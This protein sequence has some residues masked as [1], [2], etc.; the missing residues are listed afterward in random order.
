MKAQTP[1]FRKFWFEIRIPL[2]YFVIGIVWIFFSDQLVDSHFHDIKSIAFFSI[3]KGLLYV[4]VTT[5]LLFY[6][7]KRHMKKVNEQQ[8]LMET[9]FETITDSI[10]ITDPERKVI[11]VNH[12]FTEAFGYDENEIRGDSSE[13]FY[14][15]KHEFKTFGTNFYSKGS[16]SSDDWVTLNCRKKDNTLFPAQAFAAKLIDHEG[17]WIGNLGVVHDLSEQYQYQEQIEK[18]KQKELEREAR[19]HFIL[20]NMIE[21]CQIISFDWHYLYINDVAAEH[22]GLPKEDHLNR[23]IHECYPDFIKTAGFRTLERCMIERTNL[24]YENEFTYPDGKTVWFDMSIQPVPEGIFILS[25]DITERKKT[26]L[27]VQEEKAKLE[28]AIE[29]MTDAVCISD[30]QGN[31][32]EFNKSF[33]TFHK[34]S[35]KKECAKTLGEYPVFLDVWFPDGRL[36]PMDQWAVP[37]ALRGETVSNAEYHLQRKDTGEQWIGSYSFAPIR[38]KEGNIT[39]SVVVGRDITDQKKAEEK[40]RYQEMILNETGR[41]AKVGG[42]EIDVPSEKVTWTDELYFLHD[43]DLNTPLTMHKVIGF[44]PEESRLILDTCMNEAITTAKPFD[45]EVRINTDIGRLI[46]GRIIG[47][48]VVNNGKV[49]KVQ[50]S[51]QDITHRKEAEEII[52]RSEEKYQLVAENSN[53]WVYLVAPDKN[54]VFVSPS[55][56]R[57]TGYAPEE[58]ID[59]PGRMMKIIYP[60]DKQFMETHFGSM[61]DTEDTNPIEFRILTKTGDV[62]WIS[63]TCSPIFTKDNVYVGRRGINRD[64]TKEKEATDKLISSEGRYRSLFEN[65]IEGFAYCKMIYENGEPVDWLYIAV[66]NSFERLTGLKDINGRYVSEVIPGIRESDPELF[67]TYARVATTGIPEKFETYVNALEMWFW[68]SV[69]SPL[70]DHFVAV[71]DVITERKKREEELRRL[72]TELEQLVEERAAELSDLYNNAP[73]GYHSLD[74]NGTFVRI[75]DTELKWLGYSR[76]EIIGKKRALDL[77]T[78]ASCEIFSRSFP[79]FKKSKKLENIELEFNRKD[80]TILPVLLNATALDDSDGNFMMS[81]STM[82]DYTERRLAD[83][84]IRESQEQLQAM[85]KELEAFAYSVSHDLRAPLRAIDGFMHIIYEDYGDC[86]DEEGHRLFDVVRTNARKMD[87]LITDLLALSRISRGDLIPSK[88]DMNKL[89][90]SVYFELTVPEIREEVLFVADPLPAAF[91]DTTLIR[92]IWTNLLGNALKYTR[93]KNERSIHIGGYSEEEMNIFFVKDNGVGFDPRYAH[94]LFGIFQRLHKTTEFEGTGV[95]LA[96]VQRIIFRHGGKVW[97][98]GEPNAGATFYFS[99]P[100]KIVHS[101]NGGNYDE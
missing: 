85:N 68:I 95:G 24:R 65:L 70:K 76:D 17:K 86:L 22:G 57:I 49:T 61:L 81:R 40:I 13:K 27:A 96:I 10:I 64:V 88:L 69:Y 98:E 18:I 51:F 53:D 89:V 42:W 87:Q 16:K 82:I 80:G 48:P 14:E 37:R 72:N 97:A 77:F 28:T 83:K 101:N 91:G 79:V 60:E 33:A 66:N 39:G 12:A 8:V 62:V 1:S 41:I 34:F 2:I 74:R 32:I 26:E 23:T 52:R 90:Q 58:F 38:D 30:T 71:F 36:A 92:Q 99:L 15:S 43:M 45:V 55:S 44:C 31:F 93:D 100:S 50:G 73:C 63:H 29:S 56:K 5:F 4:A 35:S 59:D 19:I 21:G 78:P 94:K 46:W 11:S 75:N 7:I 9:V 47:H 3:M 54:F 25:T 67:R 20:D 84:A 6:L